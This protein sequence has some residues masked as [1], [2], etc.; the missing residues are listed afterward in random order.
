MTIEFILIFF[1]VGLNIILANTQSDSNLYLSSPP[2]ENL[3][4]MLK[5][6][7]GLKPFICIKNYGGNNIAAP[8]YPLVIRRLFV[9][10]GRS[11]VATDD[12]YHNRDFR[13]PYFKMITTSKLCLAFIE[14]ELLPQFPIVASSRIGM[15]KVFKYDAEYVKTAYLHLLQNSAPRV[16][17]LVHRN[18]PPRDYQVESWMRNEMEEWRYRTTTLIRHAQFFICAVAPEA[19]RINHVLH[20]YLIEGK[21]YVQ[22]KKL[23]TSEFLTIAEKILVKTQPKVLP[24]QGFWIDQ[25][26]RD[27]LKLGISEEIQK[28]NPMAKLNKLPLF[29]LTFKHSYNRIVFIA[30]KLFLTLIKNDSY[31]MNRSPLMCKDG[32][33]YR[34]PRLPRITFTG[35]P[36]FTYPFWSIDIVPEVVDS[37]TH[38]ISISNPYSKLKFVTCGHRG[39]TPYPFLELLKVYDTFVWCLIGFCVLF[40]PMGLWRVILSDTKK[41]KTWSSIL[42]LV[43]VLLEQGDPFPAYMVK[44]SHIRVLM[45]GFLYS[46]IVLS[47]AYKSTNVYNMVVSRK[48]L[49]YETLEQLRMD[50]FSIFSRITSLELKLMNWWNLFI[51]ENQHTIESVFN[52]TSKSTSNVLAKSEISHAYSLGET[53]GNR[54]NQSI[55]GRLFVSSSVHP[56]SR[57]ALENLVTAVLPI[58]N[59]RLSERT[60]KFACDTLPSQIRKVFWRKEK[61]WVSN[62]LQLCNKTATVL[63]EHH[64]YKEADAAKRK[65]VEFVSVGKEVYGGHNIVFDVKNKGSHV[66]LQRLSHVKGSGIIEWLIKTVAQNK[67]YVNEHSLFWPVKLAGNIQILFILLFAGMLAA[68]VIFVSEKRA[69]IVENMWILCVSQVVS[70]I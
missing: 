43:K 4:Q 9:T 19:K 32:K 27:K 21:E 11:Q 37:L 66:L 62:D 54:R 45:L 13:I 20:V 67:S 44:R 61:Y 58:I 2:I 6:F 34:S 39:T 22:E 10:M 31:L 35:R 65:G 28:C 30:S 38:H 15:I 53:K 69:A 25:G 29:Q 1:S 48:P 57:M 68:M 33:P 23:K 50:N 26:Y 12:Q 59:I 60:W 40:L 64:C 46:G 16:F 55:L 24:W 47:N 49:L 17:I 52:K 42:W 14:V 3:D 5:S 41:P 8:N 70:Y 18:K 36:S 63:P 56:N 51:I 7:Y